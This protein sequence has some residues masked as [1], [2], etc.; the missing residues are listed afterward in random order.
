MTFKGTY[1][2]LLAP[3]ANSW[4]YCMLEK[5][6]VFML[7]CHWEQQLSWGLYCIGNLCLWGTEFNFLLQLNL[8][9]FIQDSQS[10]VDL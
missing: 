2:Q 6:R 8:P 3:W 4:M 10:A 7:S 9:D 1:S 5:H